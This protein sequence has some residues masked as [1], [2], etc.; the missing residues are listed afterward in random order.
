MSSPKPTHSLPLVMAALD[1]PHRM[2]ILAALRSSSNYVSQLAR[3][4]EISRPLLIMH[5]KKLEEA[6][7]VSSGL[8]VSADGKAMR[9]YQLE[10]FDIR[11][12]PDEV[13]RAAAKLPKD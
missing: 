7:L 11:L 4:L 1:N 10:D 6:G 8:E 3:D 2:R 12:T 5:L 9:V 13:A